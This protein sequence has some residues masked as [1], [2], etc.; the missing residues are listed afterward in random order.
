MVVIGNKNENNYI[1]VCRAILIPSQF[2]VVYLECADVSVNLAHIY[3]TN[4][5][6]EMG[7]RECHLMLPHRSAVK[8]L[9]QNRGLLVA[10]YRAVI[11]QQRCTLVLHADS[12]PC[13]YL[14][15]CT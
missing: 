14:H 4:L 6:F 1:L 13:A 11:A 3:G 7:V 2:P 12:K 5:N 15:V 9:I 10:F 8:C